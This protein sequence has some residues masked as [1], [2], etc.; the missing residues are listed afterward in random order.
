MRA[1]LYQRCRLRK[2]SP[3]PAGRSVKKIVFTIIFLTLVLSSVFFWWYYQVF[4]NPQPQK[5]FV[6]FVIT[7][8]E[9][10]GTVVSRLAS[11]KLIRSS[12]AV[13]I[14][15][16]LNNL[17]GKLKPG[18]YL[19]SASDTPK[20]LID[21]I[22]KGP[23]D[24]WVTL[25]EGWRREQIA[26]QLDS[27]LT[28]PTKEFNSQEFLTLTSALEGRLFPDKYLIP[29]AI[30]ASD[31]VSLL[32]RTFTSKTGLGLSPADRETLILASLVER[33]AKT[34][35]ERNQIAAILKKRLSAG[36]PLQVDATVQFASDKSNWWHNPIDPKFP[37]AY[38]TYL[39][40]GLP[41]GPI[42]N[43]GLD[44]VIAVQNA[45]DTPYWYYMTGTDG[46]THY[47]ETLMAHNENIDKYL[48]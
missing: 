26:D 21:E 11:V 47:A 27:S 5:H 37:S 39:H 12:L 33:E 14:Y 15:L 48:K 28:G 2:I 40:P 45:S 13:K 17:S 44:S 29:D 3:G 46:V 20:E 32:T 42:C 10:A 4:I 38:N 6:S 24:V 34:P 36:W 35:S 9:P 8:N 16:R 23:K 7:A 30:S 19:L 31:A 18:G 41:P 25:P 22:V 43:P 1:D